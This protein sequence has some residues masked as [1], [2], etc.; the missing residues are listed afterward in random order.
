MTIIFSNGVYC[1]LYFRL[2]LHAHVFNTWLV[3]VS[4]GAVRGLLLYN[5]MYELFL[6]SQTPLE[7]EL[8]VETW[9]AGCRSLQG[10]NYRDR[11][12]QHWP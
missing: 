4:L 6:Y 10:V 9:S 1:M 12:A 11:S 5:T 2:I 3:C 8:G 7:P